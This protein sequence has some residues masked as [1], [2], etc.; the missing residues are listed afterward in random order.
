[1]ENIWG[2]SIEA[3]PLEDPGAAPP[4]DAYTWTTSPQAAPNEPL[5][6]LI[7]FEAGVPVALDGNRLPMAHLIESLNELGGRHGVGRIDMLE[8]RLVGLKSREIYEAPAA[9]IL[10]SAHRA[11]EDLTLTKDS[12]RFGDLVSQTYADL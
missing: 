5:V 11:I 6:L 2:R 7:D 9:V 12:L 1:D 3:G 4:E 10:H 8:N